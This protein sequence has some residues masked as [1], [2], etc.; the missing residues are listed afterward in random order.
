MGY[1]PKYCVFYVKKEHGHSRRYIHCKS[2][3]NKCHII[4]ACNRD[5]Y[6]SPSTWP[7]LNS[8]NF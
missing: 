8:S 5:F 1:Y 2:L 7:L 6:L 4:H 3:K